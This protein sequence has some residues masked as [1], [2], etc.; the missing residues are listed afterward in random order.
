MLPKKDAMDAGILDSS[1]I[2]S[3]M[4]LTIIAI[5]PKVQADLQ[6]STSRIH[7]WVE[8]ILS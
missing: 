6:S 3:T 5:Q 8:L 4:E 1:K 7:P 2:V